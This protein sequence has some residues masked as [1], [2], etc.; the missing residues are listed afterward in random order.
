M[1]DIHLLGFGSTAF[2]SRAAPPDNKHT[3]VYRLPHLPRK[4]ISFISK[5]HIWF[6]RD[7]FSA[8]KVEKRESGTFDEALEL[9]ST[10]GFRLQLNLQRHEDG[11]EEL[12]LLVKAASRVWE[13]AERQVVDDVLDAFG[14]DGRP[15]GSRHG[16]VED[17]EELTQWRLVHDVNNAHLDD[18]EVENGA[19]SCNCK[20]APQKL[21]T[22]QCG[23]CGERSG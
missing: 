5:Q 23:E 11:E 1:S 22:T 18:E 14:G 6:S 15:G 19:A 9:L 13:R 3:H 17:L 16:Q 21:Y 20:S 4:D 10:D 12:V 7:Y 8:E 2:R